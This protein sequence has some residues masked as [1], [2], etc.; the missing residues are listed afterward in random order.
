MFLTWGLPV[1][2]KEEH[3]SFHVTI[4][5]QSVKL[6]FVVLCKLQL[7]QLIAYTELSIAEQ[8]FLGIEGKVLVCLWWSVLK[9]TYYF[10]LYSITLG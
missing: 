8:S 1:P 6:Q 7:R 9:S 2:E 4:V 3:V 5:S 10:A